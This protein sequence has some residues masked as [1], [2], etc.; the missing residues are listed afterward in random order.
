M[1]KYF[2]HMFVLMTAVLAAACTMTDASAP[3][4]AGPSE[5][6]LSL[7]V[8]ANPDVLSLDGASQALITIE[9]RDANGQLAPN[10]PLRVE[11]LA[12]G[13]EIDFG[14]LS[15]RTVVTNANG[16]ATVTYTAPSC[17]GGSIPTLQIG[18]TPTGT[19]ASM[20]VRRVV[21]VRLQQPGTIG[22]LPTAAFTF[23]PTDPAAFTDVRFDGSS[24]SAGLG[25]VI[26]SYLW[27]F[28]DGTT[29]T[30]VTATHQYRSVGTF[31]AKLT[32]T[33]SN[34]LSNTSAGQTVEVS[35]GEPPTATFIYSPTSPTAGNPVFFNATQSTAGTGHRIVSYRWSWGDGTSNSSGSA[36]RHTYA[37]AGT[38]VVVLTVT[39]DAGQTDTESVEVT[40]T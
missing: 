40:V 29:G 17:C 13:Q 21:Q 24:S 39:D 10:V 32:V 31:V 8:T 36:P 33:S 19:D 22:A 20:H 38:Y 23:A 5:M 25:A 27:D 28:G 26:T 9:A 30:G 1:T 15:A 7:T 6:S 11:I 16:R 37:A 12:D 35:A 14:S 34:G 4:L 18:V 2:R 3:P